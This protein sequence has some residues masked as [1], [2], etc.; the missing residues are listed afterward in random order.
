[1]V[2]MPAK[3]AS[4]TPEPGPWNNYYCDA[5]DVGGHWCPE[6]DLMEANNVSWQT[7]PHRCNNA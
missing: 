1:M 6:M 4:G 2:L 5:N 7:T 3:T